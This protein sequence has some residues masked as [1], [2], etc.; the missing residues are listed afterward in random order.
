ML[1]FRNINVKKDQGKAIHLRAWT[2]PVVSKRLWLADFK[3][4]AT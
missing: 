3:T 2:G 1:I 4:I